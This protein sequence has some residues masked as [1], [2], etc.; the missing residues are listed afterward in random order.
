MPSCKDLYVSVFN[1]IQLH[2]PL[3]STMDT[4]LRLQDNE[5]VEAHGTESPGIRDHS[6]LMDSQLAVGL[7]HTT[8]PAVPSKRLLESL[9]NISV[10]DKESD[11]CR[12]A[13]KPVKDCVVLSLEDVWLPAAVYQVQ[14]SLKA[15]QAKV[16][17]DG[18]DQQVDSVKEARVHLLNQLKSSLKV[19]QSQRQ[20]RQEQHRIWQQQEKERQ[21]E[22]R[23]QDYLRQQEAQ[24]KNHPYNQELWREVAA[25]MTEMQKL[26]KEEQLWDE[27]LERLP[28]HLASCCQAQQEDSSSDMQVEYNEMTPMTQELGTTMQMLD[29]LQLWTAR[30]RASVAQ[31][32]PA[33]DHADALRKELYQQH[34]NTRFNG[35]PGVQQPKDLLRLL[36]QD[37]DV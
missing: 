33:M 10:D 35:Y 18:T 7:F 30:V 29:D 8:K 11:Q 32:Q 15:V 17:R 21:R 31:I 13:Q 24:R 27:A 6:S 26:D 23:K 19:L 9:Y 34:Q 22:E 3:V 5:N 12:L 1:I 16:Q 14:K 4:P 28:T 20:A 37:T 2:L 25:L 36:S